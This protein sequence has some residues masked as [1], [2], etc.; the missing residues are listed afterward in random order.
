MNK[1]LNCGTK[2]MLNIEIDR[3]IEHQG[4]KI[5]LKGIQALKCSGCNEIYLS[6]GE[7]VNNFLN[8]VRDEVC[9]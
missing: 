5:K 4:K 2:K 8:K 7:A 9:A 1:C 3:E 6:N